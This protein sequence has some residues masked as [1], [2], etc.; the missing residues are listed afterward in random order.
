MPSFQSFS[1]CM[2]PVA[3]AVDPPGPKPDAMESTHSSLRGWYVLWSAIA[4]S[5]PMN[6][7]APKIKTTE[8]S[9]RAS[10]ARVAVAAAMPTAVEAKSRAVRANATT[11]DFGKEAVIIFGLV[12]DRFRRWND[13]EDKG[14]WQQCE[15][16]LLIVVPPMWWRGR[17]I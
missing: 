4:N 11:H 10:S 7:A 9:V 2:L 8:S 13:G 6:P 16:P 3:L 15:H 5:D 17:F 14:R 12:R 1:V